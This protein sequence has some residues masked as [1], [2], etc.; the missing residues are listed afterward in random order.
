MDFCSIASNFGCKSFLQLWGVP[1][2]VAA[3]IA[4]WVGGVINFGLHN[5]VTFKD[6]HPT[7]QGISR[8]F[9]L[10]ELGNAGGLVINTLA[11]LLYTHLGLSQVAAFFT[12]L[13]TSAIWN[14]TW[15]NVVTFA[16]HPL[17]PPAEEGPSC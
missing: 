6:R 14:W 9:V 12:A 11:I 4:Y 3:P 17:N 8:R 5:C 10:F 15:N 2:V 1:L 7:L 13:N 16:R